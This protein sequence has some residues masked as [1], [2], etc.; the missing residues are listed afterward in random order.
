MI[1]QSHSNEDYVNIVIQHNDT[2]SD[3]Q[4]FALETVLHRNQV[5]YETVDTGRET[6]FCI[7]RHQF[8]SA[9]LQRELVWIQLACE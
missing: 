2:V 3:Q 7:A 8:E 5:G 9:A 1:I 6:V 4:L